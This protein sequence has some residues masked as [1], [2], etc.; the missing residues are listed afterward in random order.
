MTLP[1]HLNWNWSRMA[2]DAKLMGMG[3]FLHPL[4]HSGLQWILLLKGC[5]KTAA[6][7]SQRRR[8]THLPVDRTW[9]WAVMGGMAS[10]HLQRPLGSCHLPLLEDR[11]RNNA[12]V[13]WRVRG[14]HLDW[15]GSRVANWARP[16]GAAGS[17]PSP[18]HLTACRLP[19]LEDRL[20]VKRRM[21]MR[22]RRT[23][24]TT[25][26]RMRSTSVAGSL[27]PLRCLTS[28]RCHFLFLEDQHRVKK[29]ELS[30]RKR[31]K[32]RTTHLTLGARPTVESLPPLR[33]LESPRL[34][35]LE[36]QLRVKREELW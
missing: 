12:W 8:R 20:V 13:S 2:A 4:R 5:I 35:S 23:T 17:L 6:W 30:W 16:T 22:R 18:R 14:T 26:L 10:P 1:A 31:R 32:R 25:H 19:L 34:P 33:H 36:D 7:F 11:V 27:P 21:G 28:C 3:G 9:S 29:E 15:S 24:T